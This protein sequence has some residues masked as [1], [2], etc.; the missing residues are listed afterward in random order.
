MPK[1]TSQKK[2]LM[3]MFGIAPRQNLISFNDN[4]NITEDHLQMKKL[5]LATK[6]GITMFA[7]NLLMYLRSCF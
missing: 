5:H 7:S 3:L 1:Q 2:Y 6:R 4:Q